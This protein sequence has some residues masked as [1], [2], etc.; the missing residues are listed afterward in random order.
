[1]DER[2]GNSLELDKRRE[3]VP[4]KNYGLQNYEEKVTDFWKYTF[5]LNFLHLRYIFF[6]YIFYILHTDY[7][8][9]YCFK[10]NNWASSIDIKY[11]ILK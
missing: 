4:E 7:V 2:H 8:T 10:N 5:S 6:F 9:L 11:N 1:M 3:V